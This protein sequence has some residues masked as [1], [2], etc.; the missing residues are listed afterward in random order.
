V[1]ILRVWILVSIA[2]QV[3]NMELG[4]AP[5]KVAIIL[6]MLRLWDGVA[7][8]V[9]GWISDNTRTR[10]GR[11][12]PYILVGAILTGLTYPLLWWFPKEYGLEQN[13]QLLMTWVIGFGV[14]FYTSFTIWAMPYQSLLMEMTPDYNERNRVASVRSIMQSLASF[15]VG[16][17]GWV[18]LRPVFA[19]PETGIPSAANGMRTISLVIGGVILL[20]GVLPAIFV[21]ERYYEHVKHQD[22][23]HVPSF[24]KDWILKHPLPTGVMAISF[25]ALVFWFQ[26]VLAILSEHPF[27]ILPFFFLLLFL[28]NV[29]ETLRNFPFR[30]LAL[31]TVLFLIGTSI[32]D[33]YGRYVG[34][35]YVLG[36]DKDLSSVYQILGTTI[37][38]VCSLAMI[39]IFR[40]ISEHIGKIKT[41]AISVVCVL[42]AASTTW[43]TFTPAHP[44]WML[45]NTAF[46]G[47]G[48]AGLWLMIPSMQVDVVDDDELHSNKRREGSYAAVFSWILKLSFCVG[49]L[50]SGPLLEWTGFDWG[51]TNQ[52]SWFGDFRKSE[53][54]KNISIG[55]IEV[56]EDDAPAAPED[57]DYASFKIAYVVLDGLDPSADL[58]TA[59]AALGEKLEAIPAAPVETALVGLPKDPADQNHPVLG[60]KNVTGLETETPLENVRIGYVSTKALDDGKTESGDDG[61]TWL[62]RF[63]HRISQSRE[64]PEGFDVNS[65][66]AYVV[67]PA[68]APAPSAAELAANAKLAKMVFPKPIP[69]IADP[70]LARLDAN[71]PPSAYHNMR[72]GYVAIPVIAL[73]L[74]LVLL[75]LFPITPERAREI[76]EQLETRRGKV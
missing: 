68:D 64:R 1:D 20:L 26:D 15:V 31:F 65:W 47:I 13:H 5:T 16:G 55:Y 74:A 54:N 19:S 32:Y 6:M 50:I 57:A 76:R 66:V 45:L 72:L 28:K 10:W 22:H 59:K 21:K 51:F 44:L 33:S 36:G 40:R 70:V 35:Y 12:R 60:F 63:I 52:A 42:V 39:P 41:L 34:T 3:F 38:M 53:E 27:Y 73:I 9:M 23:V 49:F 67:L 71:Q 75:K 8:P 58:D 69:G 46:I 4:L 29:R 7:D 56:A 43:F 30:I 48:Y 11:R 25:A 14:I 2:Y 18:A 24:V 61:K 17:P 62:A 37:Y